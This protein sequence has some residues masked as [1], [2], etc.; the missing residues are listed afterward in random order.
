MRRR[1]AFS[2]GCLMIR[3]PKVLAERVK[4]YAVSIPEQYRIKTEDMPSGLPHDVHITVKYGLL[5]EDADEVARILT[6]TSPFV[7]KLGYASVFDNPDQIVLKLE[8]DSKGLRDLNKRV[9]QNLAHVNT[10]KGYTPHVTVA[11]LEHRED[12]PIYYEDLYDD[13]FV[14]EEF[15]VGQAIFSTASGKVSIISFDG[16]VY[17]IADRVARIAACVCG[18][19]SW[20]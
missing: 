6:G 20:E 10:Y 14:G 13:S 2:Y 18:C 1:M 15:E 9:C 8:V 17:P 5:T 11:Y 19:A 12:D 4:G 7:V 16:E 3:L